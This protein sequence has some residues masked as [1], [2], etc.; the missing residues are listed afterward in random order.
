[1]SERVRPGPGLTTGLEQLLGG[2][3]VTIISVGLLLGSLLLG[4][5]DSPSVRPPPTQAV[6]VL[7]PL[8]PSPPPA[9]AT[10]FVP[11][12][13]PSPPPHATDTPM[14]PT[15]T[16]AAPTT[17][18]IP[19]VPSCP[20]PPGW[21]VYIVQPGDTLAGLAWRVGSS[22]FALMQANCLSTSAIYP[23]QQIYLPPTLYA[24]PTPQPYPCGPPVGWVIYIVKPG[25]TLY[26]LSLRFGVGIE[27]IRR[28]N[29]LDGYTIY[30]GQALYLPPLY[31]TPTYIP[32]YI[33][34]PSHTPTL[35]YTP[36]PTGGPTVMPT[37][38]PTQLPPTPPSPTPTGYPTLTPTPAPTGTI[39]HTPTHTPT[40]TETSAPPTTSTFTPTPTSISPPTST[41][42]PVPSPTSPPL[43]TSTSMPTP[44]PVV[45]TSTPMSTSPPVG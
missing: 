6:G 33:P 15:F 7:S 21:F 32:T 24:T 36:T 1:M 39:S 38:T 12:P 29:C 16:A 26:S 20:R 3:A 28:A 2:L 31:P 43:S 4:Q 13:T 45:S 34:T 23:G 40:P 35:P 30:A 10:M 41:H 5:M 42:T 27:A 17:P 14:P 11:T 22:T 18:A 9:T 8:S 37:P 25:D 44:T 19:L